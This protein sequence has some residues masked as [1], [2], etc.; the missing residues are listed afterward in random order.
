VFRG[1]EFVVESPRGV[2]GQERALIE[3]MPQGA[4]GRGLVVGSLE[5]VA[6]LA[7]KKLNP[8]MEV[9]AH[10]DDAWEAEATA[11]VLARHEAAFPVIAHVGAE[12]P[13][14]PFEWVLCPFTKRGVADL[15]RERVRMS[16][17]W[18]AAGG[19][20][21]AAVD[22]PRDRF[23]RDELRRAFGV[24]P[25]AHPVRGAS[26]GVAYV[27]RRPRERL[28][29]PPA[30]WYPISIREGEETL[31]LHGRL[32]IFCHDRLDEGTR[33]LLSLMDVGG[34]R[35]IVDLGCGAGFLGL[36]ALRREPEARAVLVDSSCRALDASRRNAEAL[37]VDDR[38]VFRLSAHADRDLAVAGLFGEAD[39]E[40]DGADLVLANP[41]Y[42][43]NYR[44]SE[45]F[46]RAAHRLLRR[47]GRLQLV[48][49]GREWHRHALHE[50]F[51][52]SSEETRGG[53][54]IFT[55]QRR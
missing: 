23:L 8:A 12:P 27:A 21:Y 9:V 40:G 38:C 14:G 6:A 5:G 55:A 15:V 45:V 13:E 46:L 41:P 44:I 51:G 26:P 32:G 34:A 49:K 43:G 3:A 29:N 47:G 48:T 2:P 1:G 24:V 53:Y 54:V 25:H 52:G 20:F 7:L 22:D 39:D 35:R 18:L 11:T 17:D 10:D 33:A 4:E 30:S 50:L 42:Y 28:I 37:G 19:K 36:M 31:V 16:V